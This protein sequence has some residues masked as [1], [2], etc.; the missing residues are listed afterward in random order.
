MK[1]GSI[2]PEH[3]HSYPIQQLPE[4][5]K[6]LSKGTHV[7]KLVVSTNNMPVKVYPEKKLFL[8]GEATYLVTGGASGF[9]LELAYWLTTKGARYLVLVSRSGCKTDY[10]RQ[11]VEAM[12]QKGVNVVLINTDISNYEEVQEIMKKIRQGMPVLKG[13]IHSAAVL[14]DAT[15]KNMD[16]ERFDSVYM[17]KVMGAWNFHL[18]TEGLPIDFS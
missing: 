13:I 2:K 12:K 16:K 9:G 11:T 3:V 17:P 14:R 7:G 6:Q 4:A 1:N 8:D 10:D 15:F 5:L 18:A